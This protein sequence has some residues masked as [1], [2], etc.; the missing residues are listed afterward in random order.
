MAQITIT[1]PDAVV[2]R[3]LTAMCNTYG[4]QATL[5]DGT[6]NP[7]TQAQFARAQLAA[8]VKAVVTAYEATQAAEAARVSA[9]NTASSDIAVT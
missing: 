3:V 2:Q 9:A 8:Y 5:P 1:I 6:P 4:Y 7:Q